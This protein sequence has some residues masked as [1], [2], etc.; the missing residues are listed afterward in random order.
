[1]YRIFDLVVSIL[2]LSGRIPFPGPMK[3]QMQ[4]QLQAAVAVDSLSILT[5]LAMLVG[6]WQMLQ[7]KSYAFSPV[8]AVLAVIPC[9]S[10]CLVL[11]IPSGIWALV[12]LADEQTK[13]NFL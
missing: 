10:P 6:S 1:M 7:G 5:G 2:V 9:L 8:T 12:I 4:T 3:M 13:A 11:G